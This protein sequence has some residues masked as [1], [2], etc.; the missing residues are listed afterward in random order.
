VNINV[1]LADNGVMGSSRANDG[2]HNV[3]QSDADAT[4]M[5]QTDN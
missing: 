4:A 5:S 3:C 1:Y 2:L